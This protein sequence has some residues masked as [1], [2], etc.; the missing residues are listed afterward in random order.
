MDL[1]IMH[2]NALVAAIAAA[3]FENNKLGPENS[4]GLDCGFAWVEAPTVRFNTEQGKALKALGFKKIWSPYK[5]AYLWNPAKQPTQSI[6][7]HLA[8]ARAYI[9]AMK[10][11][12]IPMHAGSRYD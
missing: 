7:V 6:S 12:G 3:K 8:G 2:K 4:R 1:K 10:P 11:S 5:G 9:V